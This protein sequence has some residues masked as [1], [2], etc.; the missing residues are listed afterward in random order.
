MQ[1]VRAKDP[2]NDM[3][4]VIT[5]SFNSSRFI[6]DAV[7]SVISQ[8]YDKWE[9]IIVDDGSTDISSEIARRFSRDDQRIKVIELGQNMGA[10][11]A[12]NVGIRSAQGRFISFL[13][14][15]DIWTADKLAKQL[16]LFEKNQVAL[17][18]GSYEKMDA[19]GNRHH[20]VVKVPGLIT[21]G[22]LLKTCR[23]G[24]LTAVYDTKKTG[25]VEMPP[26]RMGQDYGLWLSI[27]KRGYVAVGVE[28]VVAYYRVGKK[29]LS[30]NKLHKARYQW[31]IYRKVEHLGFA[32]SIYCFV[33]Y[34]FHGLWKYS[35]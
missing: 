34:V 6:A 4:S 1:M 2:M 26:L 11:F 22:D 28:D 8:S 29:S 3:C 18:Y 13:D 12:R 21:Y 16:P 15:D 25:K 23:I 7:R 31:E 19:D 32:R 14:C 27:L 35:I 33:N 24:C 5:A 20:R 17:V 30:S 9:L 10:A